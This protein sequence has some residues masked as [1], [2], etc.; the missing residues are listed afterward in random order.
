MMP[1]PPGAHRF[2][3]HPRALGF[4]MRPG[5][6]FVSEVEGR[7]VTT[8][9]LTDTGEADIDALPRKPGKGRPR[10]YCPFCGLEGKYRVP[11]VD[12]EAFTAHFAHADGNDRCVEGALESIRHRLA[13]Q[14]L[15]AG[16]RTL[17]ATGRALYGEVPCLRRRRPFARE[18]LAADGWGD[19]REEVEDAASGRRPDVVALQG[20]ASAFFFEVHVSH[21]VDEEKSSVYEAGTVAGV[22][23][24]AAVLLDNENRPRW[25]DRMPL[26]PPMARWHLERPPRAFSLCE[27][28][29]AAGGDYAALAT[30]LEDLGQERLPLARYLL[31]AAAQRME[32]SATAVLAVGAQALADAPRR[33]EALRVSLGVAAAE[34]LARRTRWP[35]AKALLFEGLGVKEDW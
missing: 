20:A 15:V 32:L 19:E 3:P 22:E 27:G 5:L 21:R 6:R 17:R 24:D 26:G 4:Q 18:L 30:F 13:K 25:T 2:S 33:P 9:V 7:L 11:Q 28:C 8:R 35:S 23:L 1:P 31:H 10:V 14:V 16:L 12:P 34:V 29:R